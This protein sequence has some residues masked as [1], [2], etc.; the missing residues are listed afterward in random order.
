MCLPKVLGGLGIRS[1]SRMNIALLA[2]QGWNLLTDA[3]SFVGLSL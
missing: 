2:R 3:P 1:L